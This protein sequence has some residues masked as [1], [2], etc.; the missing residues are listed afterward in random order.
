M[1]WALGGGC[2]VA[3]APRRL[4]PIT[5]LNPRS[6]AVQE[7]LQ[8][9]KAESLLG[10]S[11][12]ALAPV[13]SNRWFMLAADAQRKLWVARPATSN[14]ER[15]HE[16]G[17][18]APRGL[19]EAFASA[20]PCTIYVLR[21]QIQF[22]TYSLADYAKSSREG[23]YALTM[24]AP[25][26]IYPQVILPLFHWSHAHSKL[27]TAFTQSYA[28]SQRLDGDEA[29]KRG[30]RNAYYVVHTEDVSRPPDFDGLDAGTGQP[31]RW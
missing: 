31:C 24:L 25:T 29:D 12:S 11:H 13:L 17:H 9:T 20:R 4:G 19:P 15:P 28:G 27:A 8:K 1:P 7:K 10:R 2:L 16:A 21:A 22:R 6:A 5:T 30:P 23:A 3:G 26:Q 14:K 18:T